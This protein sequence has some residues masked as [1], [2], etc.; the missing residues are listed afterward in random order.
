MCEGFAD[1]VTI[2]YQSVQASRRGGDMHS[3]DRV[4]RERGLRDAVLAGD[5]RA[6]RTLYDESFAGLYAY[7]LW[8]CAGLRDRADEAVQ[9]TWLTA[10]CRVGRFDPDA[11]S[12]AGWLRGIA[13]NVLRNQFR[14]ER[15]RR[16]SGRLRDLADD[17]GRSR[18]PARQ[19]EDRAERIVAALSALPD[20]YEAVL[21][22]KYLE[23]RSV[24]DIALEVRETPKA[25]ESL[26]SRARQ[27]FRDAYGTEEDTHHA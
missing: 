26:L 17:S 4:W 5:E 25:I 18:D 16:P 20:R 24:A 3:G 7:V 12:F 22:A 6:W 19:A 21:R 8:R 27:A 1:P 10:V 9:E 14:R 23:G 11:G 2:Y 13:A 15:V